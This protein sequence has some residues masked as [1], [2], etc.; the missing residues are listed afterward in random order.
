MQEKNVRRDTS[1]E[2]RRK[3]VRLT[4]SSPEIV[5]KEFSGYIIMRIMREDFKTRCQQRIMRADA[6]LQMLEESLS[7]A[8]GRH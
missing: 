8:Y 2:S 5:R 4:L 1:L 3:D 6:E 7:F